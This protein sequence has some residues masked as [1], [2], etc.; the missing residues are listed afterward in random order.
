MSYE[1]VKMIVFLT[2]VLMLWLDIGLVYKEG[3]FLLNHV[4]KHTLLVFILLL[5]QIVRRSMAVLP[6]KYG[7][8]RSRYYLNI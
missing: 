1:T 5:F 6:L 3:L 8:S 7:C 4:Y 2:K